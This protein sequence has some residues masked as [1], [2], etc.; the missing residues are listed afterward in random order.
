[1]R[2]KTVIK[3]GLLV[4]VIWVLLIVVQTNNLGF[5]G[6]DFTAHI[7]LGIV[8]LLS[9]VIAFWPKSWKQ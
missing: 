4:S 9:C 6:L 2:K 3:I 7:V 8:V 1:M 5:A